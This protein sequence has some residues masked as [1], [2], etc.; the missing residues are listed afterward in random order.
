MINWTE[1]VLL[2]ERALLS[3]C[4]FG[5]YSNGLRLAHAVVTGSVL[6]PLFCVSSF[7]QCLRVLPC[8]EKGLAPGLIRDHTKNLAKFRQDFEVKQKER[9]DTWKQKNKDVNVI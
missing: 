3:R 6:A 2:Y 1:L 4:P 9:S 8:D 5:V 7:L